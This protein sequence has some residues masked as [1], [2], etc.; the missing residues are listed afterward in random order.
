MNILSHL[1]LRTKLALLMVL[2]TVALVA[3]IGGAASV[4]HDRMLQDRIDKLHAVTDSAVGL[5]Q[6]LENE[7]VAGRLTRERALAQFGNA[8]H[9]IRFDGGAGY[10]VA[11]TLENRIVVHGALPQLDNTP[12]TAK[13]S[14]GRPLTDIIAETL[15]DRDQGTVSYYFFRAGEKEAQPKV[16]YVTRFT[17]WNVVFVVSAYTDDLV[18]S[19]RLTLRELALIS[20]GILTFTLLAAWLVN[21]DI[22]G[23]LGRLKAAMGRLSQGE[24][25]ADIPGTERRDEIGVMAGA[26]LVFKDGLRRADRLAAEQLQDRARAETAKREAMIA[27]AER[28]ESESGNAVAIISHRTAAMA[29]TANSMSNSA[30]RTGE[31]AQSAATAAAQALANA[32]TVAS[33]AEQLTA[34]IREIG[35][36]VSQ[37]TAVVGRAV[38]A[39][40]T[41]RETIE[42]LNEQVGRIGAVADMIGEIAAKTN[43]LALNAT[44]EAARAGDAGKGFAVVASEVK[45]LATQTARSTEEIARHIRDVRTATGASV[46]AVGHIEAT[47]GEIDAIAGSIAAAVEEQ[48]A[49]TAE[50]ARN[51]TETAAAANEMTARTS[52]VSGEAEATGQ[53][54]ADVLQNTTALEAAIRDLQHTVVHVVRTATTEVDRRQIRRRPC[55]VE[56]TVSCEGR[57]AAGSVHDISEHGCFVASAL[58]G[59]VGERIDL[60]LSHSGRRLQGSVIARAEDGLHVRWTGGEITAADADR[61]SVTT[62]GELVAHTKDDHI[63]FVKRVTDAVT[64]RDASALDDLSSHHSCRLGRWFDSVSDPATLALPSYNAIMEPHQAVHDSGRQ[65]LAAVAAGDLSTAQQIL[66]ELRRHSEQVLSCLDRFGRDYPATI[67]AEQVEG[68]RSQIAA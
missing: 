55:L 54:A 50:I 31:S 22:S 68:A 44:I 40:R 32:Q 3:S 47:I 41:T 63:A 2:S 43:L 18:T 14:R 53:H 26:V 27:M 36:Q 9:A 60:V 33:A 10:I 42:A 12:S 56:A 23:S 46:T 30:K 67:T 61:I 49:A 34:S 15:R 7:V 16:G 8:A 64:R 45:Q 24:H 4:M 57:S 28:I 37:S 20:G 6:S 59:Q 39:G 25:D 1:R 17:P 13:D 19:F 29:E 52:D 48:G 66:G 35:G 5:A 51:V 65:A 38:E 58:Q 11:Q 21:R 62:I